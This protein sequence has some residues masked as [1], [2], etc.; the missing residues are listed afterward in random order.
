MDGLV[1]DCSISSANIPEILQPYIKPFKW[2]VI[3]SLDLLLMLVSP[4][5]MFGRYHSLC[6][7]ALVQDCSNSI[8]DA[9]EL[10]QCYTKPLW[11]IDDKLCW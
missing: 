8:T 7:A 9:L 6:I 5:E 2:N 3:I 4:V 10:P 1:L 11:F